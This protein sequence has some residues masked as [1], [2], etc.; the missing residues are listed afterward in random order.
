MES[1]YKRRQLLVNNYPSKNLLQ[2]SQDIRQLFQGTSTV[3]RLLVNEETSLNH[4]M[5]LPLISSAVR[6]F[7]I[8]FLS[9]HPLRA[10]M[11]P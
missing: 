2:A 8:S 11:T 4:P 7:K 5:S 6:E 3:N 1:N 9:N 10:I